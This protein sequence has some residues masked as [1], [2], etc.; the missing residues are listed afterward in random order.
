MR[1]VRQSM[2][3]I[4]A[5][6]GNASTMSTKSVCPPV[7]P[8][9]CGERINILDCFQ[10]LNGSSPRVRGTPFES[11]LSSASVRF[12][13][14]GAGN[15]GK[16][17]QASSGYSVHPR[18]CGERIEFRNPICRH[19]GSSPRVRG[20]L[21]TAKLNSNSQRFIPAGAGNAT[22]TTASSPSSTVH[23]RGC[24]ERSTDGQ[25]IFQHNGSSPRVRGTH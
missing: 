25:F 23:P 8:R 5:G 21:D 12:I 17:A 18:G 3:F 14:A 11:I 7:H 6:A 19:Y 22:S 20:T 13:P 4:P 10:N 2:R 1:R 16:M 15:A 24:G 9:G